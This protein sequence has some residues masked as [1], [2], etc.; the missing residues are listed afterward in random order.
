MNWGQGLTIFIIS[1]VLIILTLAVVSMRQTNEMIDDNY[2]QKEL[3]YQK[4]IDGQQRLAQAL[5]G[6]VFLIDSAGALYFRYPDCKESADG[7][8][9]FIKPD[10]KKLDTIV[11]VQ[12]KP[13]GQAVSKA[14]LKKGNYRI[15]VSWRCGQDFYYYDTTKVNL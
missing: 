15:R 11:P 4:L 14:I 13:E 6:R 8:I 3:E 2:Y 10:N 1:F 9:E 5:H 12:Y 7:S